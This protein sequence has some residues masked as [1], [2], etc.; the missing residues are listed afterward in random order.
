MLL[1]K[2][3][4]ARKFWKTFGSISIANDR[5]VR[6]SLPEKIL[7]PDGV[8]SANKVEYMQVWVDHF[9]TLFNPLDIGLGQRQFDRKRQA[10]TL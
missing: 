3:S 4:N 6:Q 7:K 8:L 9:K 10:E 2:L 1:M 5:L